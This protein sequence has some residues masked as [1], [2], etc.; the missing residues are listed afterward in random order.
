MSACATTIPCLTPVKRG[1]TWEIQFAWTDATG[2][3][4]DLTDHT[5]RMQVR[6]RKTKE[7]VAEAD[8]VT[9]AD[10]PTTG[11][12]TATFLPTTTAEVAP[13]TYYTDLELT[14]DTGKVTSSGT[15]SLP[16]L[17]DITLPV[18]P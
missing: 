3:A 17:E 15:L 5:G 1:D 13:E 10:D 11:I 6:T 18:V 2:T 12:V 8:T 14:S 9:L 7:L 16:V 4:L